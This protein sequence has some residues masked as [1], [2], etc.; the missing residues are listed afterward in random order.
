MFDGPGHGVVQGP[1]EGDGGDAAVGRRRQ[2]PATG[3]AGDDE[4]GDGRQLPSGHEQSAPGPGPA[5]APVA[6]GGGTGG[7]H[8]PQDDDPDERPQ[9]P[10]I[11]GQVGDDDDVV[12][13]QGGEAGHG[14]GLQHQG[15]AGQG[16]EGPP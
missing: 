1:V 11:G 10:Q 14:G 12:L 13:G 15:D 2:G 7:G 3:Q 8:S 16:E 9:R 6:D 4:Q 5:G